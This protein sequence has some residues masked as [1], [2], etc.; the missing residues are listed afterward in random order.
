M[1]GKGALKMLKRRIK[2]AKLPECFDSQSLR[3]VGIRE[4]LRG[5]G[6]LQTVARIAG[7]SSASS[8]LAQLGVEQVL[9]NEEIDRIVI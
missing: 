3:L 9:G 2:Q 6:D 7:Y 1:T 4:Y 5:G 8:L